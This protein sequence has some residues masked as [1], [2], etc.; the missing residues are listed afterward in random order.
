[1]EDLLRLW[2]LVV[3]TQQR[4]KGAPDP[5]ALLELQL[6]KAA[7]LPS[8][9]PLDQIL[10]EAIAMPARSRP[11]AREP[12]RPEEPRS[13]PPEVNDQHQEASE[14]L[15]FK[16]LIPFQRMD[17]AEARSLETKDDRSSRFRAEAS[18]RMPLIGH[19]L[20]QAGLSLDPDGVLHISLPATS[21]TGIALL[22]SRERREALEAVAREVGYP[23]SI[24][25]ENSGT[26]SEEAK[27]PVRSSAATKESDQAVQN[28]LRTL[29]GQVIKVSPLAPPLPNGG[30]HGEP[31]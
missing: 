2:D 29:G 25:V 22:S 14:G 18:R 27:A 26:D 16:A 11:A 4:L 9:L 7:L 20:D 30:T 12:A 17:E 13:A 28:V 6:V 15:R 1:M 31:E 24:V 8:I 5:D 21:A 19:T 10:G 3:A 23:G